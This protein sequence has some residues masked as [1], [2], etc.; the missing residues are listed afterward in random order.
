MLTSEQVHLL[1][2]ASQFDVHRWSDYPEVNEVIEC[3]CCPEIQDFR[4][5]TY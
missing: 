4:S 5:P 2:T 1:K 3:H